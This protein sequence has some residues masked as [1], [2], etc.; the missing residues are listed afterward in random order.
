VEVTRPPFDFSP[1]SL[2]SEFPV[3]RRFAYF[4]HA[5]VAPLPRRVADAII[6]HTESVRDRGAAD[7]RAWYAAIDSTRE[8][9]AVFLGARKT[10]I[11]FAPNTTLGLQT[12]A[13]G[14]DFQPGDN[15]VGDDMEFPS[16][17]FPWKLLEARR[18]V[19][20]RTAKSR[21][22]RVTAED[23][24][25][26]I[27][28]RT[29]VVA[30]S[31]VAFHNGWVYPIAEIARLC[32]ER[33]ILFVVD[34]IQ[35]LGVLPLPLGEDGPDV[36]VADGHKWL[37][38]PEGCALLY[39]SQAAQERLAPMTAGWWNTISGDRYLDYRLDFHRG[40]RR[41][42][43]GTLPTASL[44]GLSAAIDLLSEIGGEQ[45]RTRIRA[46]L[47]ALADGLAARG[48]T[49]TTPKPFASAILAAAPPGADA[50][51]AAKRFEQAGVIVSPREGAV[52]FSPHVGNDPAEVA[53]ILKIADELS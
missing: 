40:A 44:A 45:I 36:A 13:S 38:G 25:A 50:R 20:F 17:Y 10:E 23:V 16:N 7:W 27:D 26:V 19:A 47:A 49:I 32:R 18:G 8:K 5:A 35:G 21:E 11:A 4:N 53:R 31:F 43:P 28:G 14:F 15:V 42:E 30:L 39:V 46:T 24:A 52:R 51:R 6:A 1:E 9:A 34:A 3:R 22:G 2:D 37:L 48:W 29:R 12:V 33:G 41:Y